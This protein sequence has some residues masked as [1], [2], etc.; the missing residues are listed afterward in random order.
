M[1]MLDREKEAVEAGDVVILVKGS[2]EAW[3]VHVAPGETSHTKAGIFAH[4]DIAG[5]PWGASA[6]GR[7]PSG[8]VYARILR[9]SAELWMRVLPHRT[10]I[11][12][13]AD[14]AF[15]AEMLDVRAGATVVESGTGS[16]SFTHFLAR[17]VGP[18]GR[19]LTYDYHETRAAAAQREFDAHG[20]GL[21]VRAACR[22][23]C[24]DGFG[25]GACAD[26]VF[27]DLPSPW[28]AMRHA[29]AALRRDRA[30]RVG[31]FSPCIE[32]VQR[33]V[34]EMVALGLAHVEMHEVVHRPL[35]LEAV[36][37]ADPTVPEAR[38]V[39]ALMARHETQMKSHTSYLYFA[40]HLPQP[41]TENEG[42]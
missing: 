6:V 32:Q 12:Y 41:D 39:R 31:V 40:V 37:V 21:V 34:A 25:A 5:R 7:G 11:I 16:G 10:Q 42:S 20:L 35:E 22:D 18:K 9:P 8:P 30:G 24:A 4:A 14:A 23:V 19:V 27:L 1:G 13:T 28:L 2:D 38:P 33:T 3:P 29:V 15:I 36:D 17:A 26:A